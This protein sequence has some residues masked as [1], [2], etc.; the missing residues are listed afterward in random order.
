ML[1]GELNQFI[2]LHSLLKVICSIV[3]LHN[4]KLL[5]REIEESDH[6]IFKRKDDVQYSIV[7]RDQQGGLESSNVEIDER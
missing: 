4:M 2:T 7:Q 1:R 5:E 3:G 6:E